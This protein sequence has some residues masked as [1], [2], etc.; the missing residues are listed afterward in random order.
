MNPVVSHDL[1]KDRAQP[2]GKIDEEI[3]RAEYFTE[4][5][6]A[7]GS[8]QQYNNRYGD[9]ELKQRK[10]HHTSYRRDQQLDQSHGDHLR[11]E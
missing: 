7:V 4:N 6:S 2:H 3:Q 8:L 10:I 1:V 9:R 11:R 5:R